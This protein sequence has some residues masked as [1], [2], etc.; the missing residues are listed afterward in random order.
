MTVSP[1]RRNYILPGRKSMRFS[2]LLAFLA[3]IG[4]VALSYW[5]DAMPHVHDVDHLA[6]ISQEMGIDPVQHVHAPGHLPDSDDM[7]HIAAHVVLQTITIP[8][9]PILAEIL[10]PRLTMWSLSPAETGRPSA[11][12]SILRPPQG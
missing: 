12:L 1:A 10:V 7:M 5:H 4:M 3:L 6:G 2:A 9:S 11:P 8:A